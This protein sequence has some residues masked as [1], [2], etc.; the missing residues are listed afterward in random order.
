MNNV[1]ATRR[2]M[3]A[4]D[5]ECI[6]DSFVVA[7]VCREKIIKSQLLP[8]EESGTTTF[9]YIYIYTGYM[10]AMESAYISLIV[11]AITLKTCFCVYTKHTVIVSIHHQKHI[12]MHKHIPFPIIHVVCLIIM[13][14]MFQ[15]LSF[16]LYV[17]KQR[18]VQHERS[19]HQP[20]R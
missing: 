10:N 13:P 14:M 5:E 11:V 12:H 19:Q 17:D 16:S 2:R 3:D 1:R 9:Q 6:H 4:A 8:K 20:K 15:D 18:N 7:G